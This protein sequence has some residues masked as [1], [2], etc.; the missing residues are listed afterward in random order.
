MHSHLCC[1]SYIF[2][3]FCKKFPIQSQQE[4]DISSFDCDQVNFKKFL[5]FGV[6]KAK[7]K[8]ITVFVL[9]WCFATVKKNHFFFFMSCEVLV[10]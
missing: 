4:E 1:N 9:G 3:Y 5:D 2:F 6:Q 10:F 8:R 7:E